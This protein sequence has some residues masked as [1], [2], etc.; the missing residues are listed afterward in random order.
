MD[1]LCARGDAPGKPVV[2][3]GPNKKAL[4]AVSEQRPFT[5]EEMKG[6]PAPVAKKGTFDL[7]GAAG[8]EA[9]KD[10]DGF[11]P[12][13][14]TTNRVEHYAQAGKARSYRQKDPRSGRALSFHGPFGHKDNA[15]AYAAGMGLG[16][17]NVRSRPAGFVVEEP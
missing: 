4:M 1:K 8:K 17:K 16:A 13:R 14:D 9:R 10:G 6:H 5:A 12:A 11:D 3:R 7:S 2:I 15:R